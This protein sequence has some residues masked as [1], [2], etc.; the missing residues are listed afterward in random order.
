GGEIGCV[1]PCAEQPGGVEGQGR[2][3]QPSPPKDSPKAG[4]HKVG[5][6]RRQPPGHGVPQPGRRRRV[7]GRGSAG[8]VFPP[9]RAR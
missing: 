8:P 4:Q 5:R 6:R 3:L 7:L 9:N 2:R 1:F